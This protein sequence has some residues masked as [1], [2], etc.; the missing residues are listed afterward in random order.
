MSAP[1][2]RSLTAYGRR[3]YSLVRHAMVIRCR[4]CALDETPAQHARLSFRR[5]VE[6]AGLTGRNAVF[7]VNQLDFTALN[8]VSQP[9]R[10]RRSC[11]TN[12]DE[13]LASVIGEGLLE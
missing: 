10:L 7:A 9:G 5:I 13:D 3:G 11:G 12:F 8:A 1:M 4:R 2:R 6:H